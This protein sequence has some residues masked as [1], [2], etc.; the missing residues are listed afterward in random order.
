MFK[1]IEFDD[2]SG[3]VTNEYI[4]MFE[5]KYDIIFPELLK[6]FY[7]EHNF[8]ELKEHCFVLHKDI[9][10]QIDF[11][12]PIA[13]ANDNVEKGISFV[14]KNYKDMPSSFVPLARDIESEYYYWDKND[15]RV[16]CVSIGNPEHPIP[17]SNNIKEFFQ[18]LN[19]A[20][21]YGSSRENP[22]YPQIDVSWRYAGEKPEL[23]V[24]LEKKRT[25]KKKD[26]L[27]G[28]LLGKK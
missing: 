6:Q 2:Q 28:K 9:K 24:E 13:G 14:L 17:V 11:I 1:F 20:V 21:A 10:F 5:E 27:F 4:D 16:Y 7:T 12:L 8:A 23:W 19:E 18:V 25:E 15:E 26:S 22:Y 3:N